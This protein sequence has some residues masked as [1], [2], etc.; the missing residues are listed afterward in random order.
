MLL[1]PEKVDN[2]VVNINVITPEV[3][4]AEFAYCNAMKQI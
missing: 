3:L 1:E 2:M 4:V